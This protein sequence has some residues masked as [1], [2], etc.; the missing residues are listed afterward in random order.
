M[1]LKHIGLYKLNGHTPEPVD[2]LIEW[3]EFMENADR[4]VALTEINGIFI[5][6]VF[7]GLDHNHA[8]G[9]PYLFETMTFVDGQGEWQDRCSTWDEAEQ[10]HAQM[11]Q[12]VQDHFDAA[13][14]AALD[15]IDQIKAP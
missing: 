5:S 9:R 1:P 4:K 12:R 13:S 6:T 3:G 8:G 14:Y 7:L 15:V 11:C 2:C 10:M